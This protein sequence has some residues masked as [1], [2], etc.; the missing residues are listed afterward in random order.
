MEFRLDGAESRLSCSRETSR[1][2]LVV[3]ETS[4]GRAV[5]GAQARA[6]R[7]PSASRHASR[8]ASYTGGPTGKMSTCENTRID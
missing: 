7:R 8:T 1:Y 6:K 5:C 4:F 2:S 3:I